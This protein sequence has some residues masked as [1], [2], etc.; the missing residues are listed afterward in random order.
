MKATLLSLIVG[1]L[2]LGSS[3]A[4]NPVPLRF[5]GTNHPPLNP[6]RRVILVHG[7]LE[8]GSNFRTLRKRLERQ[9]IEC[10]VPK[11]RP[12]NGRGGLG[13]LAE[14]LKLDIEAAYGTDQRISIIAFSMGGLVSRHYLQNLGGATR[15]DKLFTISSPHHGT[16]AARIFPT[17]GAEQ[18]RPGSP[19]LANLKATEYRLGTMSVVSYRTPMD[20][21]ILPPVS[22]VWGRAENLKYPV[23][24]HP[25]M[26]T[27]RAVL[28]DIEQ[29]LSE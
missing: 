20:L 16:Q 18:M 10:L 7:F 14:R 2:A 12:N 26:L 11:L 5:Q 22:S 21:I 23:L 13:G 8:N 15:C 29:R 4:R 6:I 1:L 17:K 9:G 19:F 24:L 28:T 25:L 27:S 3:Q